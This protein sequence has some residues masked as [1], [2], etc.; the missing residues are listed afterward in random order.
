MNR[1]NLTYYPI[2]PNATL[3]STLVGITFTGKEKDEESGYGYFGARYMDHELMTMWLS[4]D[5][6]A[7]VSP[8]ISPYHYCHWNPIRLTDP[9]GMLDYEWQ[10]DSRTGQTVKTG[11]GGGESHHTV[12][13]INMDGSTSVQELD[14]TNIQF[15]Y[16]N[17]GFDNQQYVG[18]RVFAWFPSTQVDG[19]CVNLNMDSPIPDEAI[20]GLSGMGDMVMGAA[21]LVNNFSGEESQYINQY[22]NYC[23]KKFHMPRGSLTSSKIT[24][25]K[26]NYKIMKGFGKLGYWGGGAL[27]LYGTISE[28]VTFSDN[29]TWGTGIRTGLSLAATVAG[30]VCVSGPAAPFVAIGVMAWGIFDVF[31]GDDLFDF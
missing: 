16:Y 29:P 9:T 30:F 1:S 6:M 3:S 10:C 19:I 26:N 22:Q 24:E 27:S 14:G 2:T 25:L 11:E 23:R 7:N 28:G 13:I 15:K 21:S 8:N 12:T 18:W 31:W 5:P 4:V 20:S 17:Y